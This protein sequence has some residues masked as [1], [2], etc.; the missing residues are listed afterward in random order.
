MLPTWAKE[1]L[2]LTSVTRGAVL[3][4]EFKRKASLRQELKRIEHRLE[5]LLHGLG[6]VHAG[7]IVEN[8]I[9][10]F[11]T[12]HS[13]TCKMK[14]N[15]ITIIERRVLLIPLHTPNHALLIRCRNDLEVGYTFQILEL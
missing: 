1:P 5:V 12:L 3:L 2:L 13:D 15:A 6:I 7:G 11:I 8:V 14:S 10:D 9:E 4:F